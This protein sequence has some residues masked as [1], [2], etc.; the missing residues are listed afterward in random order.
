[1]FDSIR[2]EFSFLLAGNHGGSPDDGFPSFRSSFRGENCAV[3]REGGGFEFREAP[4]I[5]S[6]G[7]N[8]PKYI[9]DSRT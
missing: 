9:V 6:S 8:L 7:R 3:M 1:M 5:I 2:Y 4:S